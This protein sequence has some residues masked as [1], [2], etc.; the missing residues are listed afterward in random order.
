MKG[1]RIIWFKTL[2]SVS[3]LGQLFLFFLTVLSPAI[4]L[5]RPSNGLQVDQRGRPE[6]TMSGG[7]TNPAQD[8]NTSSRLDTSYWI[9]QYKVQRN[10]NVV[11]FMIFFCHWLH[12]AASDKKISK[13]H[14]H[15]SVKR[16]SQCI[17][18]VKSLLHSPQTNTDLWTWENGGI[19][20]LF[21]NDQIN[22][23]WIYS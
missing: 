2:S 19:Q 5:S 1:Q 13:K 22:Y 15:F 9:Y 7:P 8:R 23:W 4:P 16:N 21:S 12:C 6:C 20:K 3:Y 17:N 14:F 11:T 10:E 18:G